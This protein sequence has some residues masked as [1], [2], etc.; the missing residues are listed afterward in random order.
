MPLA[1]NSC[2]NTSWPR[3]RF[4]GAHHRRGHG[5]RRPNGRFFVTAG[6]AYYRL[7][8]EASGTPLRI[9]AWVD[10]DHPYYNP[11][12]RV[13]FSAD[14]RMVAGVA[15]RDVVR[16]WD[17]ATGTVLASLAG[18][19]GGAVAVAFAADGKHRHQRR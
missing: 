5:N 10:G 3:A 11:G 19:H 8:E 18:H 14:S 2:R 17:R 15:G 4:G 1:N 12:S 9:F 7:I 6:E 16:V 13:R